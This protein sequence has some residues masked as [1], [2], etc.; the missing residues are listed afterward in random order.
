MLDNSWNDERRQI[1]MQIAIA[2]NSFR[3]E[4][5][6]VCVCVCVCARARLRAHVRVCGEVDWLADLYTVGEQ[7]RGHVVLYAK[8]LEIQ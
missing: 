5:E 1:L 6:G 2:F 8:S 3:G 4:M 7:H